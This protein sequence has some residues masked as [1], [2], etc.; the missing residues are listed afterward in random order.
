MAESAS[1]SAAPLPVAARPGS[2]LVVDDDATGRSLLVRRLVK[3]GHAVAE[4]ADGAAALARIAAGG[5]ELVLLDV[6]MPGMNGLEVLAALRR[7]HDA[8]E[9]PVIMVTADDSDA[10]MAQAFD[11][12]AS[13]YATKPI[14]FEALLRRVEVH[15]GRRRAEIALRTSEERFVLSLRA[16]NQ[17]LWDWNREAGAIY[18]SPGWKRMIGY[19]KADGPA[20]FADWLA[21]IHPEDRDGFQAAIDA[22]VEGR[23]PKLDVEYRIRHRSGDHRW[24][25]SRGAAYASPRGGAV[26]RIVGAQHD[27]TDRKLVDVVTGLPNRIQFQE[28]LEQV[29]RAEPRRPFAVALVNIDRFRLI[30][31]ALG[32]R[33][34]DALLKL[35]AQRLRAGL[36]AGHLIARLGGDHFALLTEGIA[37]Q[38][39]VSELIAECRRRFDAPIVID[40]QAIRVSFRIGAV[41]ADAEH[42]GAGDLLHHADL[43]LR[44][45]KLQPEGRV[46]FAE[47][48]ARGV[49]LSRL[50]LENDLH[51]ALAEDE[52]IAVYHPIVALDTGRTVGFE[53]LARWLKP[54]RGMIPPGV[55]IGVAEE[56]GLISAI[57]GKVLALACREAVS[58]PGE[59]FVSVNVSGYRF[60]DPAL[61]AG[62][63]AEIARSGLAPGRLKLEITE[64]TIMTDASATARTVEAIAGR[65]IGVAIDDF[66]TGYSSLAYLHRFA[67]TTLK[68]DRSFVTAM[69]ESEQGLA[70]VRTI[71]MLARTLDMTVVAEGIETQAQCDALRAL[72]CQFG[73]GYLFAKP[74]SAEDAR[75]RLAFETDPLKEAI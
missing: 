52:F 1:Q 42:R 68:I 22:Y 46:A 21:Q 4:A 69:V 2:I 9:L 15:L 7:D 37:D 74:L 39:A 16:A 28:A 54:G 66:G 17:G 24:V 30:N 11:A 19:D 26:S 73:Q 33:A 51:R 38:A 25:R 71:I 53:A 36:P 18:F 8:G 41:I 75:R 63:D 65:G 44:S 55:F 10:R 43:A 31:E 14:A 6:A 56:T 47:R 64:S 27:I 67:A 40:D 23:A 45:A 60:G 70:I 59:P 61:V 50:Q 29:L 5:I 20:S 32:P 12:G 34:G 13:D 3:R 72:G 58:W 62:I 48:P 49:A 57:D 35:F